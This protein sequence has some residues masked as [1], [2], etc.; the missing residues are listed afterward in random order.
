MILELFHQKKLESEVF[1]VK[2]FIDKPD[3]NL[4]NTIGLS[5]FI[6]QFIKYF[7]ILHDKGL[8]LLVDDINDGADYYV[9]FGHNYHH[10]IDR[11]AG[12]IDSKKIIYITASVEVD[13]I[14]FR[15]ILDVASYPPKAIIGSSKFVVD[16]FK[17]AFELIC[18]KENA[19][20]FNIN[21]QAVKNIFNN[22]YF[23]YVYLYV[24]GNVY[25][26]L[27]LTQENK[28]DIK[29]KFGIKTKFNFI[30]NGII[31]DVPNDR[32]QIFELIRLFGESFNSSDDVGLIIKTGLTNYCY[33]YMAQTSVIRVLKNYLY[34]LNKYNDNIYFVINRLT[35]D[36]INLLYNISD[37]FLS[38]SSGEGF[39]YAFLEAA[40]CGLPIM[41]LNHSA[42]TEFLEITKIDYRLDKPPQTLFNNFGYMYNDS[43]S[44]FPYVESSSFVNKTRRF[45]NDRSY[46][47]YAYERAIR[48]INTLKSNGFAAPD[49]GAIK[50]NDIIQLIHKSN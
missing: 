39:G 44:N 26:K 42:Y 48:Q 33:T 36:N 12:R 10:V 19:N 2:I 41:A 46:Y 34:T 28:N 1:M 40:L 20:K 30:F 3:A 22:I 18:I 9:V 8:I 7:E 11:F 27:D 49:S 23:D 25:K 16:A 50:L 13:T 5:K 35:D 29:N 32:K 47:N 37:A 4:D 38:I 45:V 14:S 31:T 6:L 43:V 21:V 15:Q 24:D 17:N